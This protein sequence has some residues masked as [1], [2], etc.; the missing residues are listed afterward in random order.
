MHRGNGQTADNTAKSTITGKNGKVSGSTLLAV[1]VQGEAR[2]H[3]SS[4]ETELGTC[5]RTPTEL[6]SLLF[7]SLIHAE[8]NQRHLHSITASTRWTQ[9]MTALRHRRLSSIAWDVIY[10]IM[11]F[12]AIMHAYSPTARQVSQLNHWDKRIVTQP[13]L[14]FLQARASRTRWWARRRAKASYRD[15]VTSSSRR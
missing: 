1:A 12:R 14:L 9:R 8:N 7:S 4:S 5:S 15:S 6:S 2:L 10:W 13:Q 3:E 11:H